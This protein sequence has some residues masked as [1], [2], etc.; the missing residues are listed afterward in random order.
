VR[1]D[2]VI[3]TGKKG[4]GLNRGVISRIKKEK[5]RN[6]VHRWY[7]AVYMYTKARC[8]MCICVHCTHK[9]TLLVN[10][11]EKK[12]NEKNKII[13]FRSIL[14]G[15]G[16]SAMHST[17]YIIVTRVEFAYRFIRRYMRAMHTRRG[18]G[19]DKYTYYNI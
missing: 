8:N 13:M 1:N 18:G 4:S 6:R 11:T 19:M 17:K 16:I 3:L 15:H 5:L 2:V 9:H 14:V 7:S 10:G 12:K